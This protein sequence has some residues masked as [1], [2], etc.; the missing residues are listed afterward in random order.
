[1]EYPD[2]YRGTESLDAVAH[3]IYNTPDRSKEWVEWSMEHPY[4]EPGGANYGYYLYGNPS[5]AELFEESSPEALD[6][7]AARMYRRKF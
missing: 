2:Q 4:R 7:R 5:A 6:A 1:M 3:R